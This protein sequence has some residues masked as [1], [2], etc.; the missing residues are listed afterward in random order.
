M[1]GGAVHMKKGSTMSD[2]EFD[3]AKYLTKV[4]GADYLEVKWRLL[5]LRTNHPNAVIETEL[6]SQDDKKAIFKATVDIPLEGGVGGGSATGWGSET[7]GDFRDY[8]EKA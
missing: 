7:F 4:S 5:W 6:I 1:P 8:L 2:N 3:P